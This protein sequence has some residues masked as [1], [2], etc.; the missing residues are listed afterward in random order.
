M[1]HRNT[2]IRVVDSVPFKA[3]GLEDMA[4]VVL[5]TKLLNLRHPLISEEAYDFIATIL[6]SPEKRAQIPQ[7]LNHVFITKHENDSK[8]YM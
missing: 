4:K 3:S 6:V 7:L 2:G 1:E 5:E 8:L